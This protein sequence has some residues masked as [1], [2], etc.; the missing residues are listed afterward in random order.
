LPPF[1]IF[2]LLLLPSFHFYA[3]IGLAV[4]RKLPLPPTGSEKPLPHIKV[5]RRY[6]N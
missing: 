3:F 5:G 1:P 6:Q 4:H 2:R